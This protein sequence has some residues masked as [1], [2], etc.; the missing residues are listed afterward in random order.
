[1]NGPPYAAESK[2]GQNKYF[3]G[4]NT[5][6]GLRYL[7][8]LNKIKISIIVFLIHKFYCG[9]PFRLLARAPKI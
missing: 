6:L 7:K 3:D 1:M 5:F 2:V 8:S 9:W 4:K